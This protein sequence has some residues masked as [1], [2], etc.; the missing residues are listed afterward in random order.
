MKSRILQSVMLIFLSIFWQTVGQPINRI[1]EPAEIVSRGPHTQIW[2][3][4]STTYDAIGDPHPLTN[5]IVQLQ[6]GLNRWDAINKTWVNAEPDFQADEAQYS[7]NKLQYPVKISK[8]A[9]DNAGAISI[10]TGPQDGLTLKCIGMAYYSAKAGQ[11]AYIALIKNSLAQQV[12]NGVFIWADAFA[13]VHADIRCQVSLDSV[14]ND[15]ILKEQLPDPIVYGFKEDD[16]RLEIW[17]KI[18]QGPNLVAKKTALTRTTGTI[19]SDDILQ[20]G[21]LKFA[22]GTAYLEDHNRIK[23]GASDQ[24]AYPTYVSK[25][26]LVIDGVSYLIESVPLTEINGQLRQLAPPVQAFVP[27][28]DQ[29]DAMLAQSPVKH[30]SVPVSLATSEPHQDK[31]SRLA[32]NDSNG[33]GLVLDYQII[34]SVGDLTLQGDTTYYV[35][36]LTTVS[37]LLTIE[38]GTVV[39]YTNGAELKITGVVKTK[40]SGYSPA[41]FTSKDDNSI[42]ATI[43][44]STGNPSTNYP[45]SIAL[46]LANSYSDI[47]NV[48]ISHAQEAIQYDS[49]S[50]DSGVP[51]RLVHAQVTHSKQGVVANNKAFSLRNV[52]MSDVLTNFANSGGASTGMVEHLTV[53]QANVMNSSG[54]IQLSLTNSLLVGVNSY[55]PYSSDHTSLGITSDF[56]RAGAGFHYIANASYQNSGTTNIHPELLADLRKMTVYPPVVIT[57]NLSGQFIFPPQAIRDT[58]T[59]AIG[60]HYWPLDYFLT[61][62]TLTT[63]SSLVLTNGAA[64]ALSGSNGGLVLQSGTKFQSEG[65]PLR[66]NIVTRPNSVQEQTAWNGGYFMFANSASYPFPQLYL[67]F[68]EV[69]VNADSGNALAAGSGAILYPVIVRD[70][71][72][73]NMTFDIYV[74]STGS[75]LIQLAFLNNILEHPY[76]NFYQDDI[77]G[78]SGF[79]LDFYNNLVRHGTIIFQNDGTTNV[80]NVKDNLFEEC[81]LTKGTDGPTAS[82]NAYYSTTSLGGTGNKTL[83]KLD[84]QVGPLGAFY[85]PTVGDQLLT[86][87]GSGSRSVADAGLYHYTYRTDQSKNGSGFAVAI[88]HQYVA[89]THTT[90]T[91]TLWVNDSIPAGSSFSYDGGDSWSWASSN[92]TSYGGSSNHVSVA[93]AGEHQHYFWNSPQTLS[94]SYGD[95]FFTYIYLTS[96]NL[97]SEI[98]L[99]WS[100]SDGTGWLHRAF[101]GADNIYFAGGARSYI[102]AIPQSGYWMRLEVPVTDVDLDGRT[103]NGMAFSLYGGKANWDYSGVIHPAMDETCVDYDSDGLPDYLEDQNGDGVYNS[104]DLASWVSN[105]TDGDGIIDNWETELG[106]NP[107][108]D[109]STQMSGRLNYSYDL[110]GRLGTV[111]GKKSEAITVDAEGNVTVAKP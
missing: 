89:L 7:A 67:R 92:P 45:A 34:N 59:L 58:N 51:N 94:L 61:N 105:D 52:L 88:G 25:E 82:N 87:V 46:H 60:Y 54:G 69:T 66:N 36:G 71:W 6:T 39:K 75:D 85:Y 101:W 23:L 84:Y 72:L 9:N 22:L 109:D 80:W 28:K 41:V 19:D 86:L 62:V 37:G 110:P 11:S 3:S 106:T 68:T 55:G 56:S 77:S 15:V 100:A 78:Y 111:S 27:N 21:P 40:T 99:Q 8:N 81:T 95:L 74:A 18:I 16:V 98:M 79:D 4:I 73:K 107:L 97:P 24:A 90:A 43:P 2:Q 102:G 29:V 104:G 57:N 96:T 26:I 42:G 70:S 76:F 30:R 10:Q 32:A 93:A 83:T 13:G 108:V 48:R 91:S 1:D 103:I 63:G 33:V 53:D 31:S 5:T 14:E 17:H 49:Y 35:S 44:G 47:R 20:A 38:G 50:G 12:K 64:I 65:T